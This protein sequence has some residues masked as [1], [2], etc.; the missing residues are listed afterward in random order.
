VPALIDI[1]QGEHKQR[2]P[3]IDEWE[4]LTIVQTHIFR[5]RMDANELTEPIVERGEGSVVWDT[6][7]KAYLDFNSGQLCFALGHNHPRAVVAAHNSVFMHPH[8][9][10]YDHGEL[11]RSGGGY[12]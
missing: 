9:A 1:L 7:A 3:G 11:V 6:S 5:A 12:P 2:G 4:L 10:V 8:P